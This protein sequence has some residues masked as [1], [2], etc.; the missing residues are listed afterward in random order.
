[1][2]A[3][4]DAGVL[5][6]VSDDQTIMPGVRVRRTGGHTMHHQVVWIESAGRHAAF[7]ADLMPTTAHVPD[8]WSPGIDLYPM[9]TLTAKSAFAAEAEEKD[10]LVFLP[11][12]PRVAAGRIRTEAGKRRFVPQRM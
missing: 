6:L 11:H 7:A 4:A 8:A 3:L 10:A 2:Q 5:E 1:L 12:D 9:D